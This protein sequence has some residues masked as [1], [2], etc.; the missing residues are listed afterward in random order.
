M[1]DKKI[2]I[3]HCTSGKDRTGFLT[4]LILLILDVKHE[5]IVFD[6][7]ESN[8]I[9]NIDLIMRH[10]SSVRPRTPKSTNRRGYNTRRCPPLP[11][12]PKHP[13]TGVDRPRPRAR[14]CPIMSA[15]APV[16][17]PVMP[18]KGQFVTEELHESS[19]GRNVFW[20]PHESGQLWVGALVAV[21]LL[22]FH[23]LVPRA[24]IHCVVD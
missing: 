16:H 2:T 1:V 21:E 19:F 9:D 20:P 12:T 4:M 14:T 7:L 6:Y 5:V 11:P 23:Q 15:P 24:L 10:M 8:K 13:H 17:D 3:F 22:P 18:I